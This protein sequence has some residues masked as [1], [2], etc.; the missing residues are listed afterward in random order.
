VARSYELEVRR[1]DGEVRT[2]L[3]TCYTER[4][5]ETGDTLMH[6]ILV[7]VTERKQLERQ[8]RDASVRDALTG[9]FNRHHL[10]E[11]RTRVEADDRRWGAVV[12]D[13]DQLKRYNDEFGHAAGD[14]ALVAMAR[15]LSRHSRAGDAVVR[16][17]GDE[18]VLLLPDIERG[19]AASLVDRIEAA[20][21]ELAPLSFAH[22][23]AVREAE[24]NLQATI[25]RADRDLLARRARHPVPVAPER[26]PR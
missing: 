10:E 22:G 23:W 1:P 25:D 11:V 3:D 14:A 7:A 20:R 24:E 18:F 12:V 8:L 17:G 21:H 2:L 9:C 15:F 5:P 4:D 13:L 6:G 19:E 16:M 26:L